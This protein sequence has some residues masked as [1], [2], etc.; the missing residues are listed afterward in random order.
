MANIGFRPT[1]QKR[2]S[3]SPNGASPIFEV[4]LFG[5]KRSLYGERLE[6]EFHRRLRPE[7]RFPSPQALARQLARDADRA[8]R[9][10]ALQARRR[11]V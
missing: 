10:F 6:V 7:R 8:K 4:H 9:V 11:V 5:Q 1:F 3:V 2:T